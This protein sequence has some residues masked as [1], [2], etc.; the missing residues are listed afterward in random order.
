MTG[1]SAKRS[2]LVG[3]VFI[4]QV[5]SNLAFPGLGILFLFLL[6]IPREYLKRSDRVVL[7]VGA[8]A[9][10]I[11]LIFGVIEFVSGPSIGY[12]FK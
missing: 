1:R 12:E 3:A 6:A 9:S 11:F 10:I 2:I 4:A 8:M 5:V 7:A